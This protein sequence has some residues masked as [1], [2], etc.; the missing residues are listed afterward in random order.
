MTGLPQLGDHDAV[1]VIASGGMGIVYE[2][3]NRRTGVSYAGKTILRA[4]DPR[5]RERFRR[6]ADLLARCD[7]HP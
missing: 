1:R 6:E 7:H 4:S 2:V 5:A 3:T